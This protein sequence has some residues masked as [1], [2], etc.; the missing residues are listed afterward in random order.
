[1]VSSLSYPHLLSINFQIKASGGG[2][3]WLAIN[4]NK[5]NGTGVKFIGK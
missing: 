2:L 3:L 4:A 1:M 5:Q